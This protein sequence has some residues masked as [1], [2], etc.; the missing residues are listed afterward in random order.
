MPTCAKCKGGINCGFFFIN[1]ASYI[2][3]LCESEA[4][5]AL[6][7]KAQL[8]MFVSSCIYLETIFEVESYCCFGA[9]VLKSPS[10]CS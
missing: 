9:Q 3:N 7:Y 1:Y 10:T 6:K 4:V 8:Q 2:F 5:L